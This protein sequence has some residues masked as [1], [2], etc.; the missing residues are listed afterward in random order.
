M[1]NILFSF[2]GRA[3]PC[4]ESLRLLAADRTAWGYRGPHGALLTD[5]LCETH[6]YQRQRALKL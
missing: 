6:S 1:T 3:A 5:A 2:H 4:S